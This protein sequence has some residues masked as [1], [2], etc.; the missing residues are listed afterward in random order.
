MLQQSTTSTRKTLTLTCS[1]CTSSFTTA[2]PLAK[3]CVPCRVEIQKDR[4]RLAQEKRRGKPLRTDQFC[5]KC[6]VHLDYRGMGKRPY[7]CDPCRAQVARDARAV[8]YARTM[9]ATQKTCAECG[10]AIQRRKTY[11][12]P[13]RDARRDIAVR[14]AIARSADARRR[15]DLMAPLPDD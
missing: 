9:G 10:A 2:S 3:F 5:R 4:V 7:Y 6:G 14:A 8:L 13:C 1:R 12:E 15:A 11:C